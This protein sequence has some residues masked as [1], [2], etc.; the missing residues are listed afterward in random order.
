VEARISNDAGF[1]VFGVTPAGTT[2]RLVKHYRSTADTNHRCPFCGAPLIE[3]SAYPRP[4]R[5]LACL[6]GNAASATSRGAL[7]CGASR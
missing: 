2:L 4:G 3:T 7:P 5:R 1:P 6:A